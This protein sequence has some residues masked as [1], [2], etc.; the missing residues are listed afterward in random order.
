[1]RLTDYFPGWQD[2]R[3]YWDYDRAGSDQKSQEEGVLHLYITSQWV[4][5]YFDFWLKSNFTDRQRQVHDQ[6]SSFLFW[7]QLSFHPFLYNQHHQ[8]HFQHHHDWIRAN[9]IINTIYIRIIAIMI[10]ITMMTTENRRFWRT[11]PQ[12]LHENQDQNWGSGKRWEWLSNVQLQHHRVPHHDELFRWWQ[13]DSSF[14][15]FDYA[16]QK[17]QE[18]EDERVR[19]EI[20]EYE[21]VRKTECL[22]TEWKWNES[23]L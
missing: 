22:R 9:I 1:M 5:L 23:G 4:Y 11:S 13:N 12:P 8:R 19:K 2:G 17:K 15:D 21:Q 18:E 6:Y 7:W 10:I 14:G 20:K 3:D 16:A